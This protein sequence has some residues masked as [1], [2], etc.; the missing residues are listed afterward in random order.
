MTL[1]LTAAASLL[2]LLSACGS[3]EAPRADAAALGYEAYRAGDLER[4]EALYGEA[5]AADPSDARALLGLG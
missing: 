1:R 3:T 2:A 4:A 5:L